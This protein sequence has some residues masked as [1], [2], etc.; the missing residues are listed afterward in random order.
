M[1]DEKTLEISL[2]ILLA[3]AA[4]ILIFQFVNTR[5]HRVHNAAVGDRLP[6]FDGID[7]AAHES[8]L[9]LALRKGC[10]FCENSMP[11]YRR[12][13]TLSWAGALSGPKEATVVTAMKRSGS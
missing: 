7:W 5:I 4:S 3:V 11:F 9:V 1:D 8:T 2:N 6:A 10:H 12:L 13:R